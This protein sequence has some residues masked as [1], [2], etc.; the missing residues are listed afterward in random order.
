[1]L[2]ESDRS[3]IKILL[4]HLNFVIDS[5]RLFHENIFDIDK[6]IHT[7]FLDSKCYVERVLMDFIPEK[8]DE[9]IRKLYPLIRKDTY[10]MNFISK[11]IHGM[12]NK[13]Y[14]EFVEDIVQKIDSH[15]DKTKFKKENFK[16]TRQDIF[17]SINEFDYTS[18]LYNDILEKYNL[19]LDNKKMISF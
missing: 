8:Y 6:L 14:E 7:Y 15:F 16:D 18:Q 1:M 4:S 10:K 11:S 9:N 3:E 19:S 13:S 17:T 2:T 12:W 5:L